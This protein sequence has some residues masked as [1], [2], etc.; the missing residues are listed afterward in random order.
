MKRFSLRLSE[1]EYQK[2]KIYCDFIQVSMNDTIR[3][4]IREWKPETSIVKDF[5]T[6]EK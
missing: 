6:K 2:L 5:E 1:A 4:I 3:H